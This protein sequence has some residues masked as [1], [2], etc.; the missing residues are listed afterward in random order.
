MFHNGYMYE[1][2]EAGHSC[3]KKIDLDGG[4]KEISV[5]DINPELFGV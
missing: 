1:G 2:T 4:N 5:L 3:I